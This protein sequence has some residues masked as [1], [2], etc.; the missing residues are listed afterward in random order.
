MSNTKECSRCREI[1]NVS[2]FRKYK[3]YCKICENL[4]N[5]AYKAAHKEEIREYNALYKDI[6]QEQ[7]SEYNKQY[8][9]VNR[10]KVLVQRNKHEKD[11]RDNDPAYKL[12]QNV[13]TY[14]NIILKANGGSKNNQSCLK[15][16]PYSIYELKQ[17]LEKQFEPWMN[18][19]NHGKYDPKIWNDNDS[20]TWTWQIDHIIPQ[21]DLPHTSMLDS[22]FEKCW[23]LA[24]LRPLSA[25]QNTADGSTKVRHANI[26]Q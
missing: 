8:K 2:D 9:T 18:W 5:K 6:H 12:R 26:I 24:N 22:N 23:S 3:T 15:R 25:K 10:D 4:S 14:I 17:H 13:S 11:R 21:S 7:L 20:T 1:K 19:D 16:L